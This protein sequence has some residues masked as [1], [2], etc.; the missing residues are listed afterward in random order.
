VRQ[1]ILITSAFLTA[2]LFALGR[3][4]GGWAYL[5]NKWH[6]AFPGH[7]DRVA[8]EQKAERCASWDSGANVIDVGTGWAGRWM[9]DGSGYAVADG[10]EHE[11]T[12]AFA[13]LDSL[14]RELP[15]RP[16]LRLAQRYDGKAIQYRVVFGS[17]LLLKDAQ[18][19]AADLADCHE[20]TATVVSPTAGL[21]V[22]TRDQ[23]VEPGVVR[24]AV[25]AASRA[26]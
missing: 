4:L 13:L 15:S 10:A 24:D 12:P 11:L 22:R 2:L 14:A 8:M 9:H 1:K 23:V 20:V 25:Q 6:A 16:D 21:D 17:G 26:H 3:F 5:S 18:G 7:P 19:L